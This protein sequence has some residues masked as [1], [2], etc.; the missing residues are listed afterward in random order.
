MIAKDKKIVAYKIFAAL[1]IGSKGFVTKSDMSEV[2]S[3]ND[4]KFVKE[5][6]GIIF[7][8]LDSNKDGKINFTDICPALIEKKELFSKS[9]L[10]EAMIYLD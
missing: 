6:I 3:E 2:F 5:E 8:S 9:N 1:D 7:E 4:V 10:R